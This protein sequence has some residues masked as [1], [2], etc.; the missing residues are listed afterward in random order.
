MMCDTEK[1]ELRLLESHRISLFL[2]RPGSI[3]SDPFLEQDANSGSRE[4]GEVGGRVPKTRLQMK[5]GR[6]QKWSDV[7]RMILESGGTEGLFPKY[8][9]IL[10]GSGHIWENKR[11]SSL[12]ALEFLHHSHS[13][14]RDQLSQEVTNTGIL[15]MSDEHTFV[16]QILREDEM[17]QAVL[18]DDLRQDSQVLLST[19]LGH[20]IRHSLSCHVQNM[21]QPDRC[22]HI[23][24]DVMHNYDKRQGGQG[25]RSVF[26]WISTNL[27]FDIFKPSYRSI[28]SIPYN[29]DRVTV[30][31]LLASVNKVRH[32]YPCQVVTVS[33]VPDGMIEDNEMG[34]PFARLFLHVVKW[35]VYLSILMFALQ[36][37]WI[38]FSF[39]THHVLEIA[40]QV[41]AMA[42]AVISSVV[43]FSHVAV[44]R[45]HV[46]PLM[47]DESDPVASTPSAVDYTYIISG[48][49]G[50]RH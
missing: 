28:I 43:H 17:F 47:G 5:I 31:D 45:F 2:N 12:T 11:F 29:S 34:N 22:Y 37:A 30:G 27:L 46:S 9:Q 35:M 38:I 20:L 14:D 48:T 7:Q 44:D 41:V 50:N 19:F 25:G 49:A 10:N 39:S 3:N 15:S 4:S 1:I 23:M 26:D 33:I 18:L 36:L 13:T 42:S 8:F 16:L 24:V 40:G 32:D 6:D 21:I